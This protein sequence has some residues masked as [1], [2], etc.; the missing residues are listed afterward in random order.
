MEKI[1]TKWPLTTVF[2]P[3][4][5]VNTVIYLKFIKYRTAPI[6]NRPFLVFVVRQSTSSQ[7]NG[8]YSHSSF[9]SFSMTAIPLGIFFLSSFPNQ[10]LY[11]LRSWSLINSWNSN[12]SQSMERNIVPIMV[13]WS[14]RDEEFSATVFFLVCSKIY[15]HRVESQLFCRV[16]NYKTYLFIYVWVYLIFESDPV[17][18]SFLRYYFNFINFSSLFR[19][20]FIAKSV[21]IYIYKWN[22]TATT[23]E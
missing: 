14:Y 18:I 9:S 19:C 16:H 15:D 5:G 7:F 3:F 8:Q 22:E 2:T 17:D 13:L 20:H 12:W 6:W 1:I 4:V 21:D 23:N 10:W 11:G